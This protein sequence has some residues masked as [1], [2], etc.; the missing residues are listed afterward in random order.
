[1]ILKPEPQDVK[2]GVSIRNAPVGQGIDFSSDDS[3]GQITEYFWK[4]GDGNTSVEANP[5]HAYT[6]PGVYKVELR[7]DFA[8]K[9]SLV[10]K[11]EI[12]IYE[13]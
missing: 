13:E 1:L 10:D 6:K 4:F 12:E 11:M 9:N 2:I 5:T 8:N 7:V 3:D